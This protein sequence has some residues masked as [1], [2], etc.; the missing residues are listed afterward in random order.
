[1]NALFGMLNRWCRLRHWLSWVVLVFLTSTAFGQTDAATRLALVGSG[2]SRGVGNALDLATALLG[3]D[4]D[5]QLLDRAEVD[6]VLREQAFSLTGMVR[7]EDA[8]KAGHLLH[9]DLFAVL[10]GTLTNELREYASLGLVVFDAKTGVRYADSALLAS[11]AVS[12]ASAV[13][14]AVRAAAVKSHRSSRDLHTVGLLSVRNADL[15]RQ[16]DSICDSVG[17]LLERELTASPGIAVLER[18]RLEQVNKERGTAPDVEGNRLLSSMRIMQLDISRDG[19][20]L[21][22]TL[23]F[24]GPADAQTNE[25]TISIPARDPAT[26]AHLLADKM[27]QFLKVPTA[28]ALA[29]REV[30]AERF[31]REYGLLLAHREYVAAVHVLDAAIAL[32]PEQA[33]WQQEMAS[34]LFNAAIAWI[35]PN[36]EF[37]PPPFLRMQP[38]S[39]D[40]AQGLALGQRGADLLLDLSRQAADQVKPGKPIPEVLN[41]S[42]FARFNRLLE[43]LSKVTATN[44]ILSA[45][46]TMLNQIQR[47]LLLTVIEPVLV[48]QSVDSNSFSAYSSELIFGVLK[49]STR[50]LDED[51]VLSTL[52]HWIEVSHKINPHDGSGNYVPLNEMLFNS[53]YESSRFSDFYRSL[54]QDPDPIIRMYARAARVNFARKSH[55]GGMVSDD[56]LAAEREFRLYA[57]DMLVNDQNAKSRSFRNRVWSVLVRILSNMFNGPGVGKEYLETC[58]FAFAQGEV[59]PD[60]FRRAAEVL[61]RPPNRNLSEALEVLDG[62]LKLMIE[63]PD[64]YPNNSPFIMDFSYVRSEE[65][66]DLQQKRDRLVA[67]LAGTNNTSAAIASPWKQSVCLLDLAKPMNGYGLLHNP[68]VQDGQVYAI[69]LGVPEWGAPEDSLQLLRVPLDGGMPAFLG[70]AKFSGLF[71]GDRASDLLR[72]INRETNTMSGSMGW[73]MGWVRA[74]CFGGGC[75]IAAPASGLNAEQGLGVYFFPTNGEPVLHLSTADGLPSDNIYALAFLDGV[76]YI[77]ADDSGHAGYLSSYDPRN[78][79]ITVLASSRRSEHLSPLDDQRPFFTLG[80]VTDST[81]HRLIM[82]LSSRAEPSP[83]NSHMITESMGIWSYSPATGEFKRLAPLRT[84]TYY[85]IASISRVWFGLANENTVAVKGPDMMALFDMRND[86]LVSTSDSWESRTNVASR[87]WFRPL[88]G[89][90]G[91]R[92]LADGPF[93]LRNGWFYSARPFERMALADGRREEFLPLR[94][95]YPFNPRE[96]LQLLDD[97]KHVLAADQISLWLLELKP[98][99]AQASVGSDND[100]SAV[101]GK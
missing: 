66:K 82:A 48:K 91:N 68:I 32:S 70:R 37:L 47:N 85:N 27:E 36:G 42:Q 24:V 59:V 86:R 3:K 33:V 6:R 97:G 21:R 95:D 56:T 11:N 41:H 83:T 44:A 43:K 78:K 4:T 28:G 30:E 53:H 45:E 100:N 76:L 39:E 38:S 12:A 71:P 15:P 49:A 2:G 7:A 51:D 98:D 31:H 46:I 80:F 88:P 69:A 8:V 90:P 94:T 75:Y 58:R 63:N 99:P 40:L 22:G 52:S 93:F 20:G 74:A 1:M 14:A 73:T 64:A 89:Y 77:G 61:D 29:D 92:T 25:I 35:D 26:L 67:E 81:R 72:R 23:A 19:D 65:I 55:G 57:Q 96:S 16:F 87:F 50:T 34:L 13:S 17:L 18:R 84:P 5:L 60:I 79:K 9:V 54:E 62:A 10:E 101:T